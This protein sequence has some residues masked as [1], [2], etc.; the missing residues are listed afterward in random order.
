MTTEHAAYMA[1]VAAA[2]DWHD[3]GYQSDRP[4]NPFPQ[5]SKHYAEWEDGFT[6]I[7]DYFINGQYLP[8]PE[9]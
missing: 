4:V 9:E 8:D 2:I 7:E 6:D 1:G 5:G 3:V